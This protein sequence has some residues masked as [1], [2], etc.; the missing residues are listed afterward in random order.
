MYKNFGYNL[1]VT[2]VDYTVLL[3]SGVLDYFFYAL[4]FLIYENS[5]INLSNI[6]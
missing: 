4:S 6:A 3:N 2:V 1:L 5:F